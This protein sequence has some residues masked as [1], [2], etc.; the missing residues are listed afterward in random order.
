MSDKKY[1]EAKNLKLILGH[2]HPVVA[3][4]RELKVTQW[5]PA[6]ESV[7]GYSAVEALG[8]N[9][10]DFNSPSDKLSTDLRFFSS[11]LDSGKND[12][13]EAI[14]RYMKNGQKKMISTHV[15][16]I[17]DS[18]GSSISGV[19]IFEDHTEH[20]YEMRR[21][22]ESLQVMKAG[23]F[24]IIN[25]SSLAL[26]CSQDMTELLKLDDDEQSD[27]GIFLGVFQKEDGKRL[28]KG[29]QMTMGSGSPGFQICCK[30]DT[31]DDG[32]QTQLFF[33]FSWAAEVHKGK[34]LR[35]YGTVSDVSHQIEEERKEQERRVDLVGKSR[36][37]A[38]SEL[39]AGVAHEINNPLA[40]VLGLIKTIPTH[41][42]HEPIDLDKLNKH[43][44][45]VNTASNRIVNVVSSLRKFA[46]DGDTEEMEQVNLG[47]LVLETI[48]FC[49]ERIE[50]H[51]IYLNIM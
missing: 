18:A 17:I 24:E 10:L 9:L 4:D 33:H 28:K 47:R 40:I 15:L 2:P 29:F 46:H 25:G 22:K 23:G 6:A 14:P 32:N 39:A 35:I 11:C 48:G 8:N 27:F 5:N 31:D 7:F 12:S 38:I 30:T 42:K 41:L 20:L 44:E 34:V 26:N 16:P 21:F 36:T 49:K 43:I 37:A 19:A 3:F 45:K 13:Q 50:S 1:I 51:N